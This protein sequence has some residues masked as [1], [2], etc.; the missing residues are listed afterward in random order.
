[1]RAEVIGTSTTKR[2]FLFIAFEN[3]LSL[4]QKPLLNALFKFGNQLSS[5]YARKLYECVLKHFFYGCYQVGLIS[6]N[7]FQW[8]YYLNLYR[9]YSQSTNN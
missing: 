2:F 5:V 3:L 6:L 9:L 1:M 4:T 8:V 7:D